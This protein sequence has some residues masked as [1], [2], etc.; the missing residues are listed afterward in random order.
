MAYVNKAKV[1]P[2]SPIIYLKIGSTVVTL[3][4]SPRQAQHIINL[5]VTESAYD[6]YSDIVFTLFDESALVVE[7]EIKRGFNNIQYRFGM[8]ETSLCPMR[9]CHIKDYDIE[10]TGGGMMLTLQ[11]VNGA[12][13]ITGHSN[14]HEEP[15]TFKGKI[16]DV[17]RQICK[18]LGYEEGNIVETDDDPNAKE[19]G[20]KSSGFDLMA[21][22]R[23][24]CTSAKSIDGESGYVLYTKD[25]EGKTYLYFEPCKKATVELYD[26]YEFVIGK[27]HENIISFKP[28]YKGLLYTLVTPS[29]SDSSTTDSS[30]TTPA[31]VDTAL[32]DG[33]KNQKMTRD[34]IGDGSGATGGS[35]G[36]A[37]VNKP[38]QGELMS[39]LIG[40]DVYPK[41]GGKLKVYSGTNSKT[42]DVVTTL[43][44]QEWADIIA[45]TASW[46]KV[47]TYL[48]KVGWVRKVDVSVGKP[49]ANFKDEDGDHKEDPKE[50]PTE[51]GLTT[52]PTDNYMT[53]TNFQSAASQAA[54]YNIGVLAP[55][56]D[57]L[58]NVLIK[59]YESDSTFKRYVGSSSY[60]SE[61]LGK[62]AEYMFTMASVLMPT[63]QLEIR[64]NALID[65]MSFVIIV[66]MTK[67][68]LFHHSSGL[69]QIMEV[70][71]NI[72]MGEFTTTLNMIKRAMQID[73]SGN[74]TLLDASEGVTADPQLGGSN[75]SDQGGNPGN[76]NNGTENIN[77]GVVDSASSDTIRKYAEKYVGLP[78]IWGG[79]GPNKK[80]YDCSGFCSEMLYDMGYKRIG[81]TANFINTGQVIPWDKS[82]ILPG[83]CLVYRQNGAGHVVM[84]VDQ[85]TVVHAPKTGDVIKYANIDYY[86]NYMQKKNGKVMRYVGNAEYKR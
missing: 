23:E 62:I 43:K 57:E 58:T 20:Y 16:S 12:L 69:Y 52:T 55:S 85:D 44:N 78:Y 3:A 79:S 38:I 66:V 76:T 35:G 68:K 7:Y 28:E 22:A 13:D 81:T 14:D 53:D 73:E 30:T 25:K 75:P 59:P 49:E 6:T 67:D 80:G 33:V 29:G 47:K 83:D 72:E 39:A 82:Q 36:S 19:E 56:V 24:L 10:F 86:W 15:K 60:N 54:K 27:E 32:G 46:Y 4:N 65:T 42:C 63:A 50:T 64:G 8:D 21:F 41:K 2:S 31:P 45:E 9:T 11:C 40:T 34:V 74:I 84:V 51:D 26:T 5:S 1:N 18:E 17:I 37:D 61:E 48:G 70:A 71:H 77:G